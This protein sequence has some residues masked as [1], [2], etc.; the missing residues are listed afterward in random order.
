MVFGLVLSL[1]VR[2]IWRC[3]F[4]GGALG[5]RGILMVV[6]EWKGGGDFGGFRS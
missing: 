4:G 1:N 5:F 6:D 3:L 2:V